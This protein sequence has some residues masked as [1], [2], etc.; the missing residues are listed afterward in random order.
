MRYFAGVMF[1][2]SRRD[3]IGDTDIKMLGIET[4]EDIDVFHRSAFALRATARQPSLASLRKSPA[5]L[6]EP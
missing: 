1:D 2:Q 3:V 6:A 4:F 5:W